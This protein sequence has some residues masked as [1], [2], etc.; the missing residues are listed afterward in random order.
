MLAYLPKIEDDQNT[1]SEPTFSRISSEVEGEQVILVSSH[2]QG[3]RITINPNEIGFDKDLVE[4][5]RLGDEV[6]LSGAFKQGSSE[7]GGKKGWLSALGLEVVPSSSTIKM[8]GH[9][10]IVLSHK[11]AGESKLLSQPKT[12]RYLIASMFRKKGLSGHAVHHVGIDLSARGFEASGSSSSSG[13]FALWQD[14]ARRAMLLP[15]RPGQPGDDYSVVLDL[16]GEKI[17]R[18][19]VGYVDLIPMIGFGSP[20]GS[21]GKS[22]GL[23]G[24]VDVE[25]IEWVEE[26]E[27]EE[28][29]E[30]EE[31]VEVKDVEEGTSEPRVVPDA[32]GQQSKVIRRLLDHVI[33]DIEGGRHDGASRD[34]SVRAT[35]GSMSSAASVVTDAEL[36]EL[37]EDMLL[38][39]RTVDL[40]EVEEVAQD[41]CPGDETPVGKDSKGLDT[42]ATTTVNTSEDEDERKQ[43]LPIG[44]MGSARSVTDEEG[45]TDDASED[46]TLVDPPNSLVKSW[47][48]LVI[49]FRGFW[50]RTLGWFRWMFGSNTDVTEDKQDRQPKVVDELTPLLR[51]VC[52]QGISAIEESQADTL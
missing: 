40:H 1:P 17:D 36:D 45:D 11:P 28:V 25:E 12:E 52:R 7:V 2:E 29:E 24:V 5:I 22:L 48:W 30:Y 27:W 38:S 33:D 3:N 43:V 16:Q 44:N 42:G 39:P 15:K 6:G 35:V 46:E 51:K 8:E 13:R 21:S 47:R 31:E 4:V 32:K 41:H 34:Q 20:A 10:T 9:E 14:E 49:F 18:A 23:I 50:L 19:R 37:R 26:K